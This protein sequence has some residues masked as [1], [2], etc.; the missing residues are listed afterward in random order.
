MGCG[1]GAAAGVV[2]GDG[3]GGQ[4]GA[5]SLVLVPL[6][7][8]PHRVM[9]CATRLRLEAMDMHMSI[10]RRQGICLSAVDEVCAR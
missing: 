5:L 1:A 6:L 7:L 4:R 3:G 2:S 8:P 9:C 10:R